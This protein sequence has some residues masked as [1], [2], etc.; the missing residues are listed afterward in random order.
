MSELR[1]LKFRDLELYGC[2][3]GQNTSALT[4]DTVRKYF[5]LLALTN[6][7]GIPFSR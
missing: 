5:I 3:N 7:P 1:K 4:S 6:V 2:L